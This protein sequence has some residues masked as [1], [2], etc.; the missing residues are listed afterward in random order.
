MQYLPCGSYEVAMT[1]LKFF[2][3]SKVSDEDNCFNILY[4]HTYLSLHPRGNT[5]TIGKVY[6]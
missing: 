3:S 5:W 2:N 4:D 1:S 6:F